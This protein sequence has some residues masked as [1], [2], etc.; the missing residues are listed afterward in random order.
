MGPVLAGSPV[1]TRKD[2]DARK[3]HPPWRVI[4]LTT[5]VILLL[6]VIFP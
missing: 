6:G 4:L 3:R 5:V 2:I 1:L